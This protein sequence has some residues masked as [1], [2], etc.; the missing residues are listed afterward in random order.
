MDKVSQTEC[1][2]RYGCNQSHIAH[3]LSDGKI[4][5]YGKKVDYDEFIK[6]KTETKDPATEFQRS[7]KDEKVVLSRKEVPKKIISKAVKEVK[8]DTVKGKVTYA[9]AKTHREA[10][11]AKIAE[12]TYKEKA[13]L[14]ISVD[15][16]KAIVEKAYTP[17]S[18]KL[19][20]LHVDLKSR[21]PDTSMEA[22]EWIE[23]HIND[24]KKS[25][26]SKS[27]G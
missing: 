15:D 10:F 13:G 3:L 19:N 21:Y 9:E 26:S 1:A 22:I 17:L 2:K 20:N 12:L 4:K 23:T 24:I 14:L 27:W 25:I 5:R 8:N 6:F 11:M 18:V 16:A 7:N